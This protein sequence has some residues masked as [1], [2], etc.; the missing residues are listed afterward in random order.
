MSSGLSPQKR[1]FRNS[2]RAF[3]DRKLE[4]VP[5]MPDNGASSSTTTHQ[6]EKLEKNQADTHPDRSVG[7]PPVYASPWSQHTVHITTSGQGHE[8]ESIWDKLTRPSNPFPRCGHSSVMTGSSGDIFIFGGMVGNKLKNDTWKIRFVRDPDASFVLGESLAHINIEASLVKTTGEAPKPRVGHLSAMAGDL[9]I[10]W[11][12]ATSVSVEETT[13]RLKDTSDNCIYTLN[14]NTRNWTKIDT[15]P[16]PEARFAAGNCMYENKIIM[17]G[18]RT[19]TG[20]HLSDIWS[21]DICSLSQGTPK[22]E[23]IEPAPGSKSPYGRCG[24]SLVVYGEEL[25]VFGGSAGIYSYPRV[26][27]DTWCFNM[28]TRIWTE[29]GWWRSFAPPSREYHAAAVIGDIM[30]VFGGSDRTSLGDTWGFKIPEHRWYRFPPTDLQPGARRDH[31]MVVIKDHVLAKDRKLVY[32]LDTKITLRHV[33][34]AESQND[35]RGKDESTMTT[36][37]APSDSTP[38]LVQDSPVRITQNIVTGTMSATKILQRLISHGRRV[39]GFR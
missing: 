6:T 26:Y 14:T 23:R 24:H 9:L 18:G 39:S 1:G 5:Q 21:F 11:G 7:V 20:K 36:G 22:W 30:Y 33:S 13:R 38:L 2:L 27:N 3:I 31:S 28:N 10:V 4:S 32:I 15:R 12:G 25:Y 16:T 8:N 29:W 35:E 17:F 37:S 19:G 34:S